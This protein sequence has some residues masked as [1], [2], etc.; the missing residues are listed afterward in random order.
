MIPLLLLVLGCLQD[1]LDFEQAFDA[2]L[3]LWLAEC[4]DEDEAACIA[5]AAEDDGDIPESCDYDPASARDCVQQMQEL[6]CP[7]Q[8]REFG[9][10]A[11]CYDAY[12]CE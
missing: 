6:P 12:G 8:T 7:W 10:P 2:E 9:F 4:Y 3:C 1:P 5:A 11:V